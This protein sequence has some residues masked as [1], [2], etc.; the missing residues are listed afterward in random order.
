MLWQS[1]DFGFLKSDTTIV[2]CHFSSQMSVVAQAYD[3]MAHERRSVEERQA[4]PIIHLRQF[5]NWIKSVLIDRY[6]PGPN[7]TIF[8]CACGKGGDIPKWKLRDPNQFVFGDIS[9]DSLVRAY[10]K[11]RSVKAKCRAFWLSGDIF[12]CDITRFIPKDVA[13]HISSCQFA[14]HY[15][16][17]SEQRA[18]NAVKNLCERLLDGGYIIITVPNACRIVRWLRNAKP[19]NTVENAFFKIIGNFNT[20]EIPLFG[21]EYIFNL[22]D[23]VDNTPEYLVHPDILIQLFQE[24]KCTL[25]EHNTFHKFYH[26]ALDCYPRATL[27]FSDLL[28]RLGEQNADMTQ[29]EWDI[30]SLYHFFVF[31][32]AGTPTP[33]PQ[34]AVW[35]V[36]KIARF[37]VKNVDTGEITEFKVE[38]KKRGR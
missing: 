25:V 1:P 5:N 21:A 19:S 33:L 35:D 20:D 29:D 4:S 16:F 38:E 17:R 22:Y 10:E 28:V 27:L 26:D 14:L 7:A 6:C 3:R 30:I 13:F 2:V 9:A 23:A 37:Q 12:K 24:H 8:E 31:Q 32:K 36:P 34:T 18:K 11:Y 15:A